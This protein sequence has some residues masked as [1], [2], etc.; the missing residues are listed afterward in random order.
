MPGHFIVFEYPREDAH[1]Y[2][3]AFQLQADVKGSVPKEQ[4]SLKSEVEKTLNVL[5]SL[6]APDQEKFR[7]YF[8]ELLALSRY[9]LVGPTAQPAQAMS[10]LE[11]L[12]QQIMDNEKGRAISA[13]VTALLKSQAIWLLVIMAL[14]V[15]IGGVMHYAFGREISAMNFQILLV[16][17]G[18]LVGLTFSSFVRC[19][20]ITFYDLHAIEADRFGP[21]LKVAFAAVIL[22]LTAA[23]LKAGVFEIKVGKT[24][25][26]AFDHDYLSAFVF[27]AI[28]GIAQEPIIARIESIKKQFGG[29]RRQR[30]TQSRSRP[31]R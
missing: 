3:I 5:R 31:A 23:F 30:N 29:V 16:A 6:F 10:T 9:G 27:G 4:A 24:E 8:V 21:G 15:G 19:R 11:N 25:L 1:P 12:Q 20:T 2:D 14:L 7:R 17:P 26:S 13:Y 28:V 18:L 22:F